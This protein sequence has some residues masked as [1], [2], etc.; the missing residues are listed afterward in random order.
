MLDLE[1]SIASLR[2]VEVDYYTEP[3]KAMDIEKL[4]LMRQC[5]K[6]E[7]EAKVLGE[8]MVTT[9]VTG[10]RRV[11]WFTNEILSEGDLDLPATQLRTI[12]YWL[13]L[14][15]H[16]GRALARCWAVEQ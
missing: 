11:R 15:Y 14:D 9:Q 4:S 16:H 6:S 3:R 7:A 1:N 10:F 5:S 8:M 13:T 12:G 2:P